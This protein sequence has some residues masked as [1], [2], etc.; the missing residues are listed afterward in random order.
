MDYVKRPHIYLGLTLS[1]NYVS[2]RIHDLLFVYV[3]GE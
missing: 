3:R 1:H 2:V